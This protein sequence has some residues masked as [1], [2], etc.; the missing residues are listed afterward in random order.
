M[1]TV[2]VDE[3]RRSAGRG[4]ANPRGDAV[5]VGDGDHVMQTQPAVVRLA[6]QADHARPAA[7]RKLNGERADTAGGAGD[8]DGLSGAQRYRP[9]R[10]PGGGPGDEQAAGGLPGDGVGLRQYGLSV[11]RPVQ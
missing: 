10:R 5:A 8:D 6:G 3:R 11:V 2:G 7:A 9:D 1:G 4:V